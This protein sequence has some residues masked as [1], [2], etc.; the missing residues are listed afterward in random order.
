MGGLRPV[1][2]AAACALAMLL[3][4]ATASAATINP[5]VTIKRTYYIQ[6]ELVSVLCPLFFSSPEQQQGS[7][8]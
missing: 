8:P 7:I 3:A 5:S 4:L 1:H 6:A 2:V